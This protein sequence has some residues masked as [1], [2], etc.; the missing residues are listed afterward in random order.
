MHLLNAR[1]LTVEQDIRKGL[2]RDEFVLHYQPIVS[3]TSGIIT[4]FESLVRWNHPTR[5]LVGPAEFIPAAEE[6]GLIVPLGEWVLRKALEQ[7]REWRRK[8]LTSGRVTVNISPR[9][10]QQR[11]LTSLIADC[12]RAYG[13][14]PG[15][16]ELEL[17]ESLVMRE[18]D[19]SLRTLHELKAMG[20]SISLDDFGT[21]YSSLNYLKRFPI[22]SLKID[23]SFIRDINDDTFDK[24]ISE[25][26]VTL[27]GSLKVRVIGEGVETREQLETLRVIG[28]DEAQG[29]LFSRPVPAD[30]A[31][32]LLTASLSL[33]G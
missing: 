14:R 22:D 3:V 32:A 27:A 2:E 17:T 25:A 18:V 19:A 31:T 5:G 12:V 10:F 24:A 9:Q 7:H 13:C 26:I 23:R 1:K 29:F 33:Y 8:G 20:V 11:E 28:C 6:S 30:Q 4:G 16:L 15:D 21:G